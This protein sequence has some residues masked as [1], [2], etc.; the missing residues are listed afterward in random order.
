[1]VNALFETVT[2]RANAI[3]NLVPSKSLPMG[4]PAHATSDAAL[5]ITE[6]GSFSLPRPAGVVRDVRPESLKAHMIP[7]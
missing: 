6:K 7:A 5:R 4:S 1:M 3:S 2:G